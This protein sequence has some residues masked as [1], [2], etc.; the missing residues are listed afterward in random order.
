MDLKEIINEAILGALVEDN[1]ELPD[2]DAKSLKIA[3]TSAKKHALKTKTEKG[4]RPGLSV[5]TV[6]GNTK[7]IDKFMSSLQKEEVDHLE[8]GPFSS[9]DKA[10]YQKKFANSA[11]YNKTASKLDREIEKSGTSY[12][13]RGSNTDI[14]KTNKSYAAQKRAQKRFDLHQ[15]LAKASDRLKREEADLDEKMIQTGTRKPT[16]PNVR[17]STNK[18]I[19]SAPRLNK[20]KPFTET[21]LAAT[22]KG[23]NVTGPDGKTRTVM[24]TTKIK[25]YDGEQDKIR[26]GKS[27][28]VWDKE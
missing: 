7:Q 28:S 2:M 9:D 21:T 17:T 15:R 12:K 18:G 22:K 26:S 13:Q 8:E 16:N 24:K 4:S 10:K 6:T 25:N 5:L 3:M 20:R 1:F 14:V 27:R 19:A 23:I 11:A